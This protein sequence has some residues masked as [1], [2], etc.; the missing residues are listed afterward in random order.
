M[1]P[2][3]APFATPTLYLESVAVIGELD[4]AC[5]DGGH[6]VVQTTPAP[7]RCEASQAMAFAMNAIGLSQWGFAERQFTPKRVLLTFALAES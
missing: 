2:V 4:G 5:R 6:E 1:R 7:P 3:I